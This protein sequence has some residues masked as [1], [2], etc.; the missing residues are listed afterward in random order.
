VY[1]FNFE[2]NIEQVR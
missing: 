1:A 2:D